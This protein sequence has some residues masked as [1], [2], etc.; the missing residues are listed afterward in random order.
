MKRVLIIIGILFLTFSIS[1]S[2]YMASPRLSGIGLP[3]FRVGIFRSFTPDGRQRL[4]QLYIQMM[5]DDLTFL[6]KKNK[7][8]AEIDYEIFIS[9][10]HKKTV[11]NHREKKVIETT[12]FEET[13][14]RD[15][16]H[17]FLTEIKLPAGSYDAI[18]SVEDRNTAKKINRKIH[19]VVN[20]LE[21]QKFL[22]SDVM[23]FSHYTLDSLGRIIDFEP[24]L[25]NNFSQGEKYIYFYFITLV[26]DS[27]DTLRIQYSIRDANG[28]LAQLNRYHLV[29]GPAYNEHYVRINR[30]QFD[31]SR[32]RLQVE[33]IYQD[34]RLT[35]SKVFSFFWT[36]VPESPRDLE[37]ALKQM[38]YIMDADSID[39]AL[40]QPYEEKLAYF[41]RFWKRMDPNPDTQKN[42]LMDEYFRRVN[43]ANENFSTMAQ[44][45][46]ETDRGRIFIKFGEPDDIERH[47]F[48]PGT[49]PYEV[50]RYY[51][52]RKIFLFIDRTGFGDYYLDPNYIDEEYN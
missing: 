10:A 17:T 7:F 1:F 52:L 12:R 46:W 48:E 32:Y 6:K 47:P 30:R 22:L 4:I 3:F 23:M 25:N 37:L 31:Q 2:Q 27:T 44:D 35:S 9:D 43:Y 18:I 26:S 8:V 14:S 24:N 11:Y 38:R 40:K 51:D 28:V 21:E 33:G 49:M 29:N 36:E 34:K 5:N 41:K 39:W 15:I 16:K 45:G 42:E 50:W 19:F 13:N 20:S